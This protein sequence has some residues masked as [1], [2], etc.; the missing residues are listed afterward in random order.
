M[1]RYRYRAAPLS[2]QP[3]FRRVHRSKTLPQLFDSLNILVPKLAARGQT[4]EGIAHGMRELLRT[5]G[6]HE[7]AAPII[8]YALQGRKG[9]A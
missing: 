8:H 3:M 6:L 7:Q 2:W 1:S 9:I 5:A 4:H